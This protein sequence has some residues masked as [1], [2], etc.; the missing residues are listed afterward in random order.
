MVFISWKESKG[1]RRGPVHGRDRQF[2]RNPYGQ[3]PFAILSCYWT[4]GGVK[5]FQ[6]KTAHE[7][8][9]CRTDLQS[10]PL[11][12]DDCKSVLLRRSQRTFEL[13][14]HGARVLGAADRLADGDTACAGSYDLVHVRRRDAAQRECG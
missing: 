8:L 4:Q 13:P 10:V 9:R 11:S 3:T 1:I 14:C 2:C 7:S 5:K 6:G 12:L